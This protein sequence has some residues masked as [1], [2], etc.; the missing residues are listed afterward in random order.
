LELLDRRRLSVAANVI[1]QEHL[2]GE[3]SALLDEH[4]MAHVVLKGALVRQILYAKPHLRPSV[5]VDLLIAPTD[6]PR[7]VRL[8]QQHGFALH[9]APHWDT[10]EA[11]LSRHGVDLDLHW[12]LLRPGRMRHD[13]AAEL[14]AGRVRRGGLWSPD[15]RHLTV[16][17]LIHSAITDYVTGPLVSVVD[18]DRWLRRCQV[19]W[20][21]VIG[22][23]ERIGLRT[24]AWTMLR[25]TCSLFATPVPDDVVRT[26]AP[27]WL[28]QKYIETWLGQHPARMY[29]QW[30][31][32]VRG[33]F[34]LALQDRASDVARALWKLASKDRL[35]FD[36]QT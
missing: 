9:Q 6:A 5:D 26:L 34:S 17:M 3:A 10:H 20:D 21:E 24:A 1:R 15:D 29:R 23:L 18:L 28:R 19:R 12:N 36:A 33:G 25:W 31:N 35:S 11:S 30:P 22:L 13:I 27:S 2:L 14:L 8:L 16:V 7:V 32:L 4:G